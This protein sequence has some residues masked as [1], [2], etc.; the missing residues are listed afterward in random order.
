TAIHHDDRAPVALPGPPQMKLWPDALAHLGFVPEELMAVHPGL[1]KRLRSVE[2]AGP[3]WA[4]Y[5]LRDVLIVGPPGPVRV[6][7]LTG[8]AAAVELARNAYLVDFSVPSCHH[9]FLPPAA[10]LASSVRVWRFTPGESLAD[11]PAALDVL[12]RL[13]ASDSDPLV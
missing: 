1:D 12:E 9:L 8:A 11:L 6:E 7:R 3:S 5:P 4:R 2:G 10:R 13:G